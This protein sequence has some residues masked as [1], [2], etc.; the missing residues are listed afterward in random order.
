MANSTKF[1]PIDINTSRMPLLRKLKATS[2]AFQ[3]LSASQARTGISRNQAGVI[4]AENVLPTSEGLR[5]VKSL[6]FTNN[7]LGG[8]LTDKID[9]SDAI[10]VNTFNIIDPQRRKAIVVFKTYFDG[11]EYRLK[12][13]TYNPEVTAL[14]YQVESNILADLKH[15]AENTEFHFTSSSIDGRSVLSVNMSYAEANIRRLKTLVFSVADNST[16]PTT[17]TDITNSLVLVTDNT[18]DTG[19][20]TTSYVDVVKGFTSYNNYFIGYTSES[21]AWSAPLSPFDFTPSLATGAGSGK[22]SGV[23]GVIKTIVASKEGFTVF[24]SAGIIAAR[25]NSNSS[26]PFIFKPIST[27]AGLDSTRHVARGSTQFAI[28]SAGLLSVKNSAVSVASAE[29]SDFITA[30]VIESYSDGKVVEHDTANL[31]STNI[32]YI[33]DRYMCISYKDRAAKVYSNM[34]VYDVVLNAF[35]KIVMEHMTSL[36]LDIDVLGKFLTYD[37]LT[38]APNRLTYEHLQSISY[39][40]L[41]TA[42]TQDAP[43]VGYTIGIVGV[44]GSI[45]VISPALELGNA[46]GVAVIGKLSIKQGVTTML[47]HVVVE[48]IPEVA[49]FK[50]KVT[51]NY[52]GALA[53]VVTTPVLTE[54]YNGVRKY[55]MLLAGSYHEI[56][57]EGSFNLTAVTVAIRGAGYV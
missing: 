7:L 9:Y 20:P 55:S 18:I 44:D 12:V 6:A 26:F 11:L 49:N 48:S 53:P 33:S 19:S 36:P 39:S 56:A 32:Q 57:L 43:S 2:V 4:Y 5:A 8:S 31:L 54:N 15:S 46:D 35:G 25:A 10:E 52:A 1:L 47:D 50:L 34:L 37:D 45:S 42:G 51:T 3:D 13:Y 38:L 41:R 22:P 14:V 30:G 29:L 40:M 16:S 21:V 23:H 24:M 27:V 28:T 17:F